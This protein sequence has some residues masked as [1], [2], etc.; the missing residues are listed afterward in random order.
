M[1]QS[2]PTSVELEQ[3][4]AMEEAQAEEDYKEADALEA[5]REIEY[6]MGDEGFYQRKNTKYCY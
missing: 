1:A 5:L 3:L 6:E 2:N 4:W